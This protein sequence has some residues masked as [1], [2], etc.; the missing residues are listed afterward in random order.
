MQKLETGSGTKGG[1]IAPQ[2]RGPIVALGGQKR[3]R[4]MKR[5]RVGR[6]A[7]VKR[8]GSIRRR[9]LGNAKGFCVRAGAVDQ[10]S[11]LLFHDRHGR[12]PIALK[13]EVWRS[14]NASGERE[15]FRL[16]CCK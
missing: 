4:W 1:N 11:T 13:G 7:G 10:R 6:A 3:C 5:D 2:F 8:A 12:E 15:N 14:L 16:Y 9:A